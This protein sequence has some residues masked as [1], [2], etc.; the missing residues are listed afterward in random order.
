M[1]T[2]IFS[3]IICLFFAHDIVCVSSCC[4]RLMFSW[5]RADLR[6]IRAGRTHY[7][8]R[9]QRTMSPVPACRLC[10]IVLFCMP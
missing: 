10:A 3:L 4:S 7:F 8:V 1:L 6:V 2:K 9:R 5:S